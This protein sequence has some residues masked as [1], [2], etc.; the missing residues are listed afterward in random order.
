MTGARRTAAE[1]RL[2]ARS[3][4]DPAVVR[5]VAAV[6]REYVLRY[7]GPDRAVVDP[8]EFAAPG[9]TFLVG[10]LDGEAVATG[11]WRRIDARTVEIKRMYVVPGARGLGLARRM[12]AALE[13]SA[14]AAGA[15]SVR[16]NTGAKQPEAVALYESSGYRPTPGFGHYAEHPGA[17]F[18]AKQLDRTG[19]RDG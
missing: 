19:P 6:Q 18:Y 2:E 16:L 4:D 14:V 3:Y 10:L 1:F 12:L 11:G 7:G 17:L 15:D 8:G 13:S 5:L 9:G